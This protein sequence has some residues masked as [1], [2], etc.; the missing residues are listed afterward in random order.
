ME[1]SLVC[2][3]ERIATEKTLKCK[4]QKPFTFTVTGSNAHL[5]GEDHEAVVRLA[6]DGSAHALSC[7]P[8]GVERQEVVLSNLKLIAKILQPSLMG[9]K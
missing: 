9:Q 5:V 8:H 6:S 3:L 2:L 1:A 4:K 7:V